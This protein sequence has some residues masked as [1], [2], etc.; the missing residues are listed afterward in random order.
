LLK[1]EGNL[2]PVTKPCRW[3]RLVWA[4]LV[5]E[6]PILINVSGHYQTSRDHHTA[7][8]ELGI[9]TKQLLSRKC[10]WVFI[11]C[12]STFLPG[13]PRSGVPT[14][15]YVYEPVNS[16]DEENSDEQVDSPRS[17]LWSLVSDSSG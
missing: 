5:Q 12:A 9:T 10:F 6:V 13:V 3:C 11:K 17:S 16:D 7:A 14:L 1:K 4:I 2:I 8:R 15:S